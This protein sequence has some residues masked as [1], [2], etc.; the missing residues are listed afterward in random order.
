MPFQSC[1]YRDNEEYFRCTLI[2]G[3]PVKSVV[4]MVHCNKILI[5]AYFSS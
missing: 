5:L 4:S 1:M 3:S 2:V